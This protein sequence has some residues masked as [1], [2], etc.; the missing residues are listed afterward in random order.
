[1]LR[2]LLS[3]LTGRKTMQT[4]AF[5]LPKDDA[6]TTTA[7][8]LKFEVVKEGEGNSPSAKDRVT[9]HYAGWLTNGTLF[10]ASYERGTPVT[11]PLDRV[12]AG[13]TEGMQLMKEGAVYRFVIPP[14]QAYGA[15]GAPPHIGPNATLVFQVELLGIG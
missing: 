10:D 15:H 4:P 12:I 2:R 6:C 8:G 11:L 3:T 1:M 7:S 13:W 14:D 9:V 5:T